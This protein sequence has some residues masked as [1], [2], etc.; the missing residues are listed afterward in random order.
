MSAASG[1]AGAAALLP[2]VLGDGESQTLH[3]STAKLGRVLRKQ[4]CSLLFCSDELSLGLGEGFRHLHDSRG[5]FLLL[6]R[7]VRLKSGAISS[8][9]LGFKIHCLAYSGGEA[10]SA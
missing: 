6:Q 9:S 8:L 3:W 4:D 2:P 10:S 7:L 1:P 5:F